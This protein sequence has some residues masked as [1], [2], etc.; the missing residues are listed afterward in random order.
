MKTKMLRTFVALLLTTLATVT[1]WAA[2]NPPTVSNKTITATKVDCSYITLTWNKATDDFTPQEDLLYILKCKYTGNSDFQEVAKLKN[3]NSY[4]TRAFPNEEYQFQIIVRDGSNR[5]TNYDVLTVKTPVDTEPPTVAN[6]DIRVIGTNTNLIQI[7]MDRCEDNVTPKDK[8]QYYLSIKKQSESTYRITDHGNLGYKP[9]Y[10]YIYRNL[11]PGTTYNILVEAYDENNNKLTYNVLTAKTETL[12][13]PPVISNRYLTISNITNESLDI[14]WEKGSDDVTPQPKLYYNLKYSLHNKDDWRFIK[15][16]RDWTSTRAGNL[17]PNTWYDF[18]VVVEDAQSQGTPYEIATAK[19]MPMYYEKDKEAPNLS[20]KKL[21]VSNATDNSLTLNWTKAVDNLFD[22]EDLSYTV[23]YREPSSGRYSR[24]GAEQGRNISSS[25]ISSLKP[26]TTYEFIVRVEDRLGN[27]ST[28]DILTYTTSNAQDK[29]APTISNKT[30]TATGVTYGSVTLTW[31]KAT[32]NVT[33]QENL[34]YS[35]FRDGVLCKKMKN[36]TSYI[37]GDLK[38]STKYTFEVRVEDEAGNISKYNT[39][40]ATTTAK[41][42]EVVKYPILIEYKQITSEN[43]NDFWGDGGSIKYDPTTK[44]L[45]LAWVD[46]MSDD[47]A[48]CLYDDITIKLIGQNTVKGSIYADYTGDLTITGDGSLSV[49]GAYPLNGW[50]SALVLKDGCTVELDATGYDSPGL[51][52]DDCLL[53]VDH[54]TLKVKGG[55]GN[56]SIRAVTTFWMDGCEF[57]SN[58]SYDKVRYM[59]LDANGKE[60]TDEIIIGPKIVKDPVL[61]NDEIEVEGVTEDGALLSWVPATD[62]TTPQ[63]DLVYTLYTMR[64]YGDSDYSFY[65]DGRNLTSCKLYNLKPNTEYYAQVRVA[66]KD[67]NLTFYKETSFKTLPESDKTV[68]TLANGTINVTDVTY[69]SASISWAKASDNVTAQ[70]KLYYMAGYKKSSEPESGLQ[71]D[72]YNA[73][74]NGNDMTSC[75]IENLD[76][77]TSYDFYVVVYDEAGNGAEYTKTTIVTEALPDVTAPSLGEV[78]ISVDDLTQTSISLS[79]SHATD[80]RTPQDKLAYTVEYRKAGESAWNTINAGNANA[81]TIDAL[82]EDTDYEVSIK[83]ADEAGNETSYGGFTITTLPVPDVTAPTLAD[84]KI[85][86]GAVTDSSISISWTAASDDR[87]AQDKLEYIVECT[88][89]ATG[90]T[91]E[92]S[93][94]NANQ[95]DITGLEP[96]TSYS[97]NVI[98]K[99]EVGNFNRYDAVEARTN[100]TPDVTAPIVVD[101]EICVDEVTDNSISISWTAATDDRTAEENLMY[102]IEYKVSGTSAMTTI[103][104]GNATSYT[105]TDLLPATTYVVVVTVDDEAGNTASYQEQE[106]QTLDPDGIL[107][108]MTDN[109]D[110]KMYNIQG[111]NVDKGYRGLVIVNGKKYLKTK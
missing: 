44:T 67:G 73:A 8:I 33:K 65:K 57:L 9:D 26:N 40:Q 19:T 17:E 30:V 63:S 69:S 54:S 52:L 56:R 29:T 21:S 53:G 105:I 31:N 4:T 16:A 85:V 25:Y 43:A 14:S 24:D 1:A 18:R 55:K 23:M 6:K 34:Q 110:A 35:V 10:W 81:Y 12:S 46:L 99:D 79:W 76:P 3:A 109:P 103:A 89:V 93:A 5:E 49:K 64:R 42:V 75:T 27:R 28:Y 7:D 82:T 50:L 97:I 80:D 32:D 92:Y 88:D 48:I 58:H 45:T 100:E 87:T 36:E 107:Q 77:E 68:P 74:G 94:G 71:F 83:V 101:S 96:N 20:N 60:A 62:D 13:N 95:Y 38:P 111:L 98:V 66:D 84:S 106:I 70:D 15:G 108:I 86:V 11:E 39:V 90:T 37:V 51:G 47:D 102:T 78:T 22:D 61:V 72:V 41:P 2:D 91:T 59:F 104:I